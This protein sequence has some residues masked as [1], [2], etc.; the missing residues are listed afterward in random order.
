MT[1]VSPLVTVVD[2]IHHDVTELKTVTHSKFNTIMF[3]SFVPACCMCRWVG[4]SVYVCLFVIVCG[5]ANEVI[6]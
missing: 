1:K 2:H 6:L 3:L 4:M 5:G